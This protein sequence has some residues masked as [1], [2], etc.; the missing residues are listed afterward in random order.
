M[1]NKLMSG[2]VKS[3]EP[4]EGMLITLVV[5]GTEVGSSV[6]A[7]MTVI[8]SFLSLKVYWNLFTLSRPTRRQAI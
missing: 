2:S 1:E 3:N 5:P 8:P 6:S 7:R 4:Q